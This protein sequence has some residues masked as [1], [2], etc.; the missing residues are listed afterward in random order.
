MCTIHTCR[1]YKQRVLPESVLFE[2]RGD[3][4]DCLIHGCDHGSKS[5]N[6]SAVREVADR[7]AV[8]A[9]V[10]LVQ[11]NQALGRLCRP[12]GVMQREIE[13]KWHFCVV[14]GSDHS[15]GRLGKQLR[16]PSS[17]LCVRRPVRVPYVD[18]LVVLPTNRG[19]ADC[20][21]GVMVLTP[22]EKTIG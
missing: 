11:I 18:A 17:I 22:G 13:E 20:R 3:V 12:V 2:R 19:A 4:E 1:P 5:V 9:A 15:L 6:D 8:V 21:F 16:R 7:A 10:I 14:M